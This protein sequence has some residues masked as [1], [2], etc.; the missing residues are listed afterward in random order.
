MVLQKQQ[1]SVAMRHTDI[2]FN[3][4]TNIPPGEVKEFKPDPAAPR[5]PD[6]VDQPYLEMSKEQPDNAPLLTNRLLPKHKIKAKHLSQGS[7]NQPY[8]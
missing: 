5:L 6:I 1:H 8:Q 2:G 4:A 3:M 7:K